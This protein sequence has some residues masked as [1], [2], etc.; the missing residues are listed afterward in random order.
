MN[1]TIKNDEIK[2]KILDTSAALLAKDARTTLAEVAKALGMAKSGVHYY[3]ADK[4]EF[5]REVYKRAIETGA[6][7]LALHASMLVLAQRDAHLLALVRE[8]APLNLDVRA[9]LPPAEAT[10]AE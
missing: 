5:V 7:S 10:A 4:H 6:A 9:C 2:N 3:F 8:H 1:T